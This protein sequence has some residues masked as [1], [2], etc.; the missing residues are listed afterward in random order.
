M[1][2]RVIAYSFVVDSVLIFKF[3][4]IRIKN[5]IKIRTLPTSVYSLI[6]KGYLLALAT[7]N[8][9]VFLIKGG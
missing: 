6:S 4:I 7:L 5:T 1:Y 2:K 9:I 3:R 8:F